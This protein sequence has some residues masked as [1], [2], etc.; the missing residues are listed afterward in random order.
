MAVSKLIE[1][2]R[3]QY[4]DVYTVGLGDSP[5]DIDF[6]AV[7]DTPVLVARPD[8]GHSRE[9]RSSVPRATLVKGIGPQGWNLAVLD[10]LERTPV[11]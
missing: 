10:I 1:L 4:D 8:G 6:L 5:N 3:Q 11:A 9:A 2:Y 7:V